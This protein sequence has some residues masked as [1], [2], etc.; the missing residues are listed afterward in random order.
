MLFSEFPK[1][2]AHNLFLNLYYT[3]IIRVLFFIFYLKLLL[4]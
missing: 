4:L 1:F 3:L 2:I